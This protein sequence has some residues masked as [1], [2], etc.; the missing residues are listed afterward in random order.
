MKRNRCTFLSPRHLLRAVSRFALGAGLATAAGLLAAPAVAQGMGAETADARSAVALIYHRFGE[1]DYPTT[2]IRLEQFE[3]HIEELSKPRYNVVTLSVIADALAEGKALPPRTVAITVDDAFLSVYREAWPRLKD[4]G[5]PF[6]LFVATDPVDRAIPGYMTWDQIR[7]MHEAGV[8]IGNHG[9][10]HAHMPGLSELR[11]RR[12]IRRAAERLEAELGDA[13][14]LFAYPYGEA[15]NALKAMVREAGYATGWGQHS[16][17][18]GPYT[19]RYYLPRFPVNESFGG[20]DR[21]IRLVNTLPIHA[22]D[23]TPDE[24]FLNAEG[25]ENP[26]AFGF[27][28]AEPLDWADSITCYHSNVGRIEDVERLGPRIE[29]RF[30]EAFQ[31]GRTRINCTSPTPQGRWRWFG[32]QYYVEP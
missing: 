16:G 15:S 6:T 5:L 3:A 24:P 27:T 11:N 7:A 8:E 19:D 10:S 4:A 17:A 9:V 25:A 29:V 13:P 14:A 28:L 2:N 30:D 1:N 32:M 26:P 22:K 20:I 18:I 21:F 23:V 12:E 31:E